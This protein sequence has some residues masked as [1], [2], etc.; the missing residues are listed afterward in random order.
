VW[1][2]DYLLVIQSKDIFRVQFCTFKNYFKKLSLIEKNI[3]E[4]VPSEH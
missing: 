1:G 2:G 4:T 3:L